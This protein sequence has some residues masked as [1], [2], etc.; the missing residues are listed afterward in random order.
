MPKDMRHVL[1]AAVDCTCETAGLPREVEFEIQTQE[2]LKGLP[3][4]SS[5]RFLPDTCED[6]VK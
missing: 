2:M 5:D 3:R 1:C 6:G 4:D